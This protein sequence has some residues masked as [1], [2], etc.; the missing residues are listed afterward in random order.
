MA[1]EKRLELVIKDSGFVTVPI[2]DGDGSKLGSFKFNP[3]DFDILKRYEHVVSELENLEIPENDGQEA[4][5]LFA[6]SDKVKELLDYLLNFKVSQ[7][8][9]AICN[10]FSLTGDGDFFVERIIEGIGGLIESTMNQR[11]AKKQAKIRKATEKYHK[12]S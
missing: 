11:L 7:D 1:Q 9:F 12:E 6:V 8:I 3:N 10:P 2:I 4:E 5:A